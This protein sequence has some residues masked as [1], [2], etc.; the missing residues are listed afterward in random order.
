MRAASRRPSS[1][2]QVPLLLDAQPGETLDAICGGEVKL[3]QRRD[4]Y[5]FNLDPILLAHFAVTAAPATPGPTIDLG[6]GCGIIPIILA[7]KLGVADV[8]GLEVQP[9]LYELARRNVHLNCCEG[10][11]S[12]LLADLRSVASTLPGGSSTHV[13]CN[14]PYRAS[15]AGRINPGHEK[16]IARHE[17]L[18]SLPD[19]AAAASYLLKDRGVL[20]LVYPA[21]RLCELF[22]ALRRTRLEPKLLR[23]VHPRVDRPA[24][25]A[26]LSSVKGGGAQ[27]DVLPPL[28][29]HPAD[30]AGFTPEVERML[31]GAGSPRA[32]LS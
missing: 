1:P 2:E 3:L 12:L 25:L 9:G 21:S 6:T 27:L 5:R 15:D 8:T 20:S 16:A 19:V 22:D 4:G 23:M 28:V 26:L 18:C 24:K 14:P 17:L 11:V 10:R 7:R 32:T 30:G 13:L 29:L 31:E